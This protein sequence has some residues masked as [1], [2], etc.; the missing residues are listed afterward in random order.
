MDF[1]LT[2][3]ETYDDERGRLVVFLKEPELSPAHKAF[4]QIYFVTFEHQGAIR[5]NHYHKKWSEWFGLVTGKLEAVLEDVWTKERKEF[6]LD[7]TS[8][9][10]TRLSIGPYVAHSFRSLSPSAALL[11]YANSKWNNHDT[12]PY[13]LIT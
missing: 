1:A 12:F 10:Y 6:I 4:G 8:N 7:A 13:P 5:G 9:Q 2:K 3:F 11:N